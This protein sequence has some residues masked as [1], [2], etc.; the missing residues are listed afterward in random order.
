MET[1][2]QARLVSGTWVV[3]SAQSAD[4]LWRT[5][6]CGLQQSCTSSTAKALRTWGA[7]QAR[8]SLSSCNRL[9]DSPQSAV[10]SGLVV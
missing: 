3:L 9:L 10:M 4:R 2:D 8:A 1:L 5:V 6:H 7:F